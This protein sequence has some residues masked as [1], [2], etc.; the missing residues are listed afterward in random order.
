MRVASARRFAQVEPTLLGLAAASMT[1]NS[2]VA[3]A[4]G[5]QRQ[6]GCSL[7]RGEGSP[8]RRTLVLLAGS[9]IAKAGSFTA[10]HQLAKATGPPRPVV[11]TWLG[12]RWPPAPNP[13]G[14]VPPCL[15]AG[16]TGDF[17]SCSVGETG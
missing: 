11:R 4:A 7:D 10:G 2:L 13:P 3:R 1:A 6:Q 5:Q 9:V 12:S 8:L 15:P 16:L 14:V 17:P